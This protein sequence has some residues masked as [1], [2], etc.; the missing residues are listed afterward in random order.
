MLKTK[1]VIAGAVLGTLTVMSSG[2]GFAADKPRARDLG[3]PF[4]GEPGPNNAITD[5]AG[6]EV[7]YSTIIEGNG[8][9]EVGKGPVRT[10]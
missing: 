1:G 2:A 6:V 3:V 5:V 4:I 8:K 9:L 10:G 7:G